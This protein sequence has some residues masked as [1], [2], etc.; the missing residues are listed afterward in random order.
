MIPFNAIKLT[1]KEQS[2]FCYA[3]TKFFSAQGSRI[4]A[5]KNFYGSFVSA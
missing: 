1:Q 3:N 4:G 5:L 2:P